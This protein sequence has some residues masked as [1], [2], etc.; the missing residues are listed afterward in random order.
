MNIKG[1]ALEFDII[2]NNGQLN[3]ALEESKKRVQGFSDATVEGGE[4]MEVAFKEAA[5]TIEKAFSD[6]DTMAGIH[7]AAISKL[8]KEYAELGE[9]AA[10]AFMK[11]TAKGDE[12]YRAITKKQQAI[13][14]ELNTRKTL[15]TEIEATAD[16]LGKEEQKLKTTQAETQKNEAAQVSMRS[17]IRELREEMMLLIDQ[18]IDEQS[19]AYKRLEAELGRLT[20]IQMDVQQQARIL[21][22]DEGAFQ[23]IIQAMS[24][25]SGAFS[26]AQG[27]ISL[28]A[29][30]NENLQKIMLKVQSLMAITIGL[31]QVAVTLNKD[32]AF[33]L[34][35]L[36]SIKNWWAGVVAKA[37]GVQAVDTAAT[38]A[39]TEA[40][41]AQTAAT[42]ANTTTQVANTVATGAQATA[43]GAGTIANI[44]L[45]GAF[46]LVGAAIKSIP[47]FGWI[48]AGISAI[49]GLVSHFTG[50]AREAKKA[51]EELNNEVAKIAGKPISAINELSHAWNLLGDNMEEKKKFIEE[52]AEKFKELGVSITNVAEAENLLITHKDAFIKSEIEKAK[53]MAVR[54]KAAELIEKAIKNEQ[55]LEEARAKPK[56]TRYVSYG[57][58]GGYS[59][60]ID[61]PEIA[62]YEKKGQEL[63]ATITEMY[64]KA[65][66]YELAGI[67]TLKETEIKGIE[68]YEAG[69][70]GALEAVILQRQALL[71]KISD[72]E[73]YKK[74]LKEIEDLQKDV[75]K[76]TGGK[77]PG[78]GGSKKTTDPY[79]EML[80]NRKKQYTQYAKWVN[81]KDEILQKAAKTEF[82][83]ILAEGSSYLEY[84]KKQREQLLALSSRTPKQNENLKKLNDEIANET[85]DTVLG[86]FEKELQ[87]QLK[88]ARSILEMLNILE[89]KRKTLT[90]DGSELDTGKAE[91]LDKTQVDVAKQAEDETKGLLKQY[92][93]Y[94]SE[95]IKFDLE[96]ANKKKVLTAALAKAT[97]EEERRIALAALDGLENDRK[98]YAKSSGNEE[99]DKLLEEYRT[100]EQKKADI[101][102]EYD[103]KIAIATEQKNDELVARLTEAKNKALSS[104]ALEELQNSGVWEKL[105]S[106]LEDLT[107]KQIEELIA[108][109]EAQKAQLGVELDPTDLET[110]L[111][112]LNEAKNEITERNPFKA[113]IGSIKEVKKELETQSFLNS[114]DPFITQLNDKKKEYE[115]YKKWV[116][117]GNDTLVKGAGQAFENLLK[118]GGSYLDYLKKKRNELSGKVEITIEDKKAINAL[119]ALIAKETEGSNATDTLTN[120]LKTMFKNSA[121]SLDLV[122]GAFDS[123]VGGLANMGL[124]GDEVT[125]GLL[126]DISQMIGSASELATGIATGNPLSIIQGSIGLI[127]SAFDVFNSRDRKA[128]RAIKKHAE[129]VKDLETAYTAL[130]WAVDKALGE[131]VYDNQKALINNMRQQQVHLQEMWKAEESKKK[132]DGNK[133]KEYKQQYEEL[134]RQIEDTIAE[135]AASITQTTAK[136]LANEL[137]DAIVE[138]FGKGEDA[139]EAFE[140]VSRKVMQNAVKNALKL[141]FLEK[142]LQNAIAQLQ[143]DMGFD[144]EGNGTFDGLTAAE[145]QRFKN[146]VSTIGSNFA[147]AMKMYEDLFKDLEDNSDPSTSLSGAIKGASQESIDLLAGQTNAVRVNQIESIDIL[148][149]QLL[150][151][152]SIDAKVGVSNNYL[153]SIDGKLSSNNGDPLRAQGITG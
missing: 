91:I 97:T 56:V 53:A 112:K 99:Y 123:V 128:E 108:K 17:R 55:K 40:Q 133:V 59:Y 144:K 25:I 88:G 115:E 70:V 15:L 33:S 27:A 142:P 146:A 138:A 12:E 143:K 41:R 107:T 37:T 87:T 81:S 58:G 90:G 121:S 145:Q 101:S 113:L 32:S 11:G 149:N 92:A 47:V 21:A 20:D 61:N 31:Q 136:D 69:T 5:D 152:A 93:G 22:N 36:G 7:K 63:N 120:K 131:T 78:S 43:A 103:E 125:Q 34:V 135:I 10:T 76:I 4:Q 110:V 62:K 26:A 118:E 147:E 94:L 96:Y 89:E 137:A 19:E 77:T 82:A 24:G 122:K 38:I 139:A 65:A 45:A 57:Y 29:G 104:A 39:N 16:A 130:A 23:G 35:T 46:R 117:S 48:L 18:G 124:A 42:A 111:N 73:E 1:G 86:E 52:N 84:L 3:S 109:I 74:A 134:G 151:L 132:T 126:G 102:E 49:I 127:S 100:F 95:K 44:G 28:F 116:N 67:T 54:A 51:Q 114:N 60:E 8:E 129:A 80:E 6:I 153:A 98:K 30:E 119:D 71:K 79:T 13:K 148:R 14:Q 106:N 9:A 72:P 105:F 2:A 64:N 66:D 50:K 75:D 85:K 140:E 83:G 150:H 68:S 141:Q